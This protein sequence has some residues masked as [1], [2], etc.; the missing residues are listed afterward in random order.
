MGSVV[1]M[2]DESAIVAPSSPKRTMLLQSTHLQDLPYGKCAP[3]HVEAVIQST[4]HSSACRNPSN[5]AIV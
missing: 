3:K 5:S 1:S 2:S 4:L